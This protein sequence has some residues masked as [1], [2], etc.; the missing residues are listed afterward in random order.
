MSQKQKAKPQISRSGDKSF[1]T[2]LPVRN[3]FISCVAKTSSGSRSVVHKL[4]CPLGVAL[5]SNRAWKEIG[6][7]LKLSPRELQIVRYVFDD[8]IESAIAADLGISPHTIHT[9]S[10]RLYRKLTVTDRVKL[11]LRIM[12]E[13]LVLTAA[14]NSGLPP[15]CANFATGRCPLSHHRVCGSPYSIRARS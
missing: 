11:V 1:S 9:Y 10:E 13:F 12:D 3:R 7:S 5:F 2:R 6:R 15:I 8:R 4:Q 14:P